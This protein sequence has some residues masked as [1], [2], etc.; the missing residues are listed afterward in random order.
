[1]FGNSSWFKSRKVADRRQYWRPTNTLERGG[2]QYAVQHDA[3][4]NTDNQQTSSQQGGIADDHLSPTSGSIEGARPPDRC[5]PVLAHISFS[6]L[7]HALILECP[8]PQIQ[9]GLRGGQV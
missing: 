5:C 1:L 2:D 3:W 8:R 7:G 9:Q 4:A 6:K